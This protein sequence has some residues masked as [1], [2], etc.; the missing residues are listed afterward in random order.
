M[1]DIKR[2]IK[3]VTNTRQITKAMELVASAKLKKAKER[4]EN[5]KPYFLTV[6]NTLEKIA[7]SSKGIDN[8]Y[9][10]QREVKNKGYIVIAGDRGLAGGYNSNILKMAVSD[11]AGKKETIIPIGKKSVEFFSKR[12]YKI[13]K[14]FVGVTEDLDYSDASDIAK[15]GMELYEKGEIDELYVVFTEF[16]S[17][18]TQIP[19]MLKLLPLS[20]DENESKD[21]EKKLDLISYDPSEEVALQY[22]IPKFL[23]SSIYGG[24][25]ESAASEQG[26]R[27]TAMESATDNA[28]EMIGKLELSYNRARQASITQELSEIVAGAEALK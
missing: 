16:K 21:N 11:M 9:L 12:G 5:S 27:R 20:F 4:V 15:I 8:I 14:E 28:D 26:A 2:R 19:K 17:A 25:V 1:K 3:S 23:A 24:I 13:V 7:K 10:K 18:L 22:I 6:Y